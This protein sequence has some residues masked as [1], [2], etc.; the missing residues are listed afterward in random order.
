MVYQRQP[1]VERLID[2]IAKFAASFLDSQKENKPSEEKQMSPTSSDSEDEEMNPFV[3]KIFDYCLEVFCQDSMI[4]MINTQ[5]LILRL[6]RWIIYA[7]FLQHH[8]ANDKAV[9]FRL[10]QL[11]NQLLSNMGEEAQ[12]DDSLYDR[13][14]EIPT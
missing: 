12:I 14:V 10:C 3:V 2:F 1:P 13:Q 5:F 7:A 8:D 9:R 6:K 11:I 4:R